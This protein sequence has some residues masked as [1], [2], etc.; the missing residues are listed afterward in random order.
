M[1]RASIT[2]DEGMDREAGKAHTLLWLFAPRQSMAPNESDDRAVH[3]LKRRL[4]VVTPDG[5]DIAA[6]T[7]HCPIKG[8]GQTV[9]RCHSCSRLLAGHT[10]TLECLV[11]ALS[12]G[13]SDLCGDL[14]PRE[15]LV[16]DADLPAAEGLAMLQA[17]QLTSAPVIDDNRLLLGLTLASSLAA[18]AQIPEAAVDDAVT[19]AVA[20]NERLT[21]AGAAQ[22]MALRELDRLPIVDDEGRLL[23][24][25]TALEVVRWFSR[26]RQPVAS[27]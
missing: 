25:L 1:P 16:L 21:V 10:N 9:E 17:A 27:R 14:L 2:L 7:V 13:A 20:A 26:P 4:V 11:P 15:T 24:V 18:I 5:T 19:D 12:T 8:A 22:V 3:L 6:T 23:G